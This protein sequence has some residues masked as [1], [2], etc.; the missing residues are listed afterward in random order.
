MVTIKTDSAVTLPEYRLSSDRWAIAMRP[1]ISRWF[2][3]N[4]RPIDVLLIPCG[5]TAV[6][7]DRTTVPETY[8]CCT[9]RLLDHGPIE[10][11]RVL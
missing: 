7:R 5:S 8:P 6:R 1:V 3:E 4:H 10:H 11:R 2:R 9:R